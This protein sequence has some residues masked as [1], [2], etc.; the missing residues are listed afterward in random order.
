MFRP[1]VCRQ[2]RTSGAIQA[3]EKLNSLKGTAFRPSVNDCNYVRLQPLRVRS[4]L[5]IRPF[6]AACIAP[7]ENRLQNESRRDGHGLSSAK[8][9]QI[10]GAIGF[11]T[12]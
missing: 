1:R 2:K 5:S 9:V 7:R 11:L 10:G 4:S 8:G 6:S 12:M 3:A